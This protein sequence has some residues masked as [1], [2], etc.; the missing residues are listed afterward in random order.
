M[1]CARAETHPGA[2]PKADWNRA[3]DGIFLC[4]VAVFLLLN[5]MGALPWGFWFDAISLWPLLIMS[6]GVKIAFEKT[7]AP[8][9]VL[10]GPA[11]V[12][13]GLTWVASGARPDD[14]AGPWTAEGPLPRPEGARRVKLD[15]DLFASRLKVHAR[16]VEGGALAD[17]RSIERRSQ[18]RLEVNREDDTAEIRLDAGTRRGVIILPGRKQRWELG[19]ASELPLRYELDGV[20]VRSRLELAESR[21]FQGGQASGV[22]LATEVELPAPAETVELAVRGVFN[23]LRVSVPEGTPVRVHG[24]GFP[25]NIVKPRSID[26]EEGRPGYDVKL[27]G[28]FSVV[29]I[30]ARPAGPAEA[31][32]VE[33]PKPEAEPGTPDLPAPDRG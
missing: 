33:R 1:A 29:K 4:G 25:F 28:I 30:E 11:I 14:M 2:V 18:S 6:A 31:P 9:L 5:T 17:A 24:T 8:W 27:D 15:L 13:S 22:F 3:A 32:P 10:L 12:L 26:G 20:M 7:K 23:I 21:D 16:E 19:V